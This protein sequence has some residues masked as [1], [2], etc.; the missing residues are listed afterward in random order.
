M[1][2]KPDDH[3]LIFYDRFLGIDE[4]EQHRRDEQH[5]GNHVERQII[6]AGGLHQIAEQDAAEET[7]YISKGVHG[8]RDGSR[9]LLAK[10]NAKCP[11][12]REHQVENAEAERQEHEDGHLARDERC[13]EHTYGGD[14]QR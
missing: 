14:G 6:V 4:T 1:E 12:R 3:P 5:G 11:C 8:A 9:M 13:Q 2:T 7:S 10:V